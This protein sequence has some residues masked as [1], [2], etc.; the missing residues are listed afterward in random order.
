[1][2]N[3]W[4]T[5]TEAELFKT[6]LLLKNEEEVASF[7]RDLMTS[8]EISEF[9]ARWQIAQQLALG[10]P[11]RQVAKEQKVSL[12]TVTRV[13]QWLKRGMNGYQNTLRKLNGINKSDKSDKFKN[14]HSH[15]KVAKATL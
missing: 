1:M 9:A 15:H 4:Y 14:L 10:K 5:K 7:C 12:A 11:Q 2:T 8:G 13:N 6:F 3:K